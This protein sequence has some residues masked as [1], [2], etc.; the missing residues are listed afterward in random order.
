MLN[1]L[2]SKQ[3]SLNGTADHNAKPS[4]ISCKRCICISFSHSVLRLYV[5]MYINYL[6]LVAAFG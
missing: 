4:Q 1:H 6:M 2:L 5:Y 3:V